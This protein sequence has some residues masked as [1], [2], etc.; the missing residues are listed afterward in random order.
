MRVARGRR[1]R[2][3]P[4][5]RVLVAVAA[6]VGVVLG[7]ASA[8]IAAPPVP[9]P[10][11]DLPASVPTATAPASVPAAQRDAALG[12]GWQTSTD[13][14]WTT[15][16]D[17]DGLHLLVADAAA[18]YAWRTVATLSE[19][20][21]EADKWI[22][23]ACVTGSGRRAV[24]VYA[25]RTFTNKADLAARGGFT[26]IVDLSTGAV[27]KL[28]VMTTL[29]YYNPGCGTGEDAVLT[30]EGGEDLG[31]TRLVQVDA[32]SAKLSAKI[33]IPGQLTSAVPT[34][35]GIVAADNGALVRVDGTGTRRVLAPTVGIAF[36]L[37]VD[38]DGGV[39]FMEQ[40]GT[41]QALVR[42]STVPKIPA[43][44]AAIPMGTVSTLTSGPLAGQDVVSGRAGRVFVTGA[45]KPAAAKLPASVSLLAAPVGSQLSTQGKLLVTAV[46]TAMPDAKTA[47]TWDPTAAQPVKITATALA[48]GRAISF[49]TPTDAGSQLQEVSAAGQRLTPALTTTA[50][51][52]ALAAGDPHSPADLADRFCSVPRNDP[53]NQAMQPKPRQVEWAVDQAVRNVL[54]VSRPA[55]WKNLGM[56][57]YTPQGLFPP[58]TL[59][60]GGFVPPQI[61]LGVA[62]QESNLWEA[63]RF[64]IPGVTANPLIG[65]YFGNN[66]YNSDPNDDWTISWADADCGYG[67][68]QVTDGMRLA[69]HT[70]PGETAYP[71]QTQR[72]VALDF[73]VNVAAGL[74]ILELKWNQV[75]GAGMTINNGNSAKIE[76]WYHALWAY[77]SGFH[78]N[79]NNG[80]P[81]GVGWAN[82]P[83]NPHY[84]ANREAFLDVT[85]GDAAHPQ[86]WP[87]EE[88]VIGWAGHPIQSIESPNVL[89]V[90]YRAASWNGGVL[91]PDPTID[92]IT[93]GSGAYNR[94]TA[95]APPRQFCDSTNN[96]AYGTSQTPNA[97][98]VVGEPAGPCQHK[99]SAGQYDLQCW[100]HNVNNTWKSDCNQTCGIELL[101][102]D[103][104]FA[105]QDDGN[106]YPPNCGL[107]GLPAGAQIVDDVPDSTPI[108]RTGCTHNFTN[109][110][111]FSFTFKP[112]SASQY[113]GKMDTHQLGAGFGGHF[114]FTH[115]RTAGAEGGKL[116]VNAAWKLNTTRNGP[117]RILVA[118]PDIATQTNNA[119]YVVK[120]A[121]GDRVRVIK[122]PGSGNRWVNLGAF[123][124]NGTP[125]VD[126]TSVA[127]DGSGDQDIAFDAVAFVPITG[128]YK[129]DSVEVVSVFDENTNIDTAAPSSWISGPIKSRQALYDWATSNVNDI[130]AMP[131]CPPEFVGDCLLPKVKAWANSWRAQVLA[132]GTDLVNHPDGNSIAK[133]IGFSNSYLDRPATD[134]R[135]ARFDDPDNIKMREKS[136]I[137]YV[138]G[139]DGKII[140][141]SEFVNYEHLLGNTHL[142]QFLLDLFAAISQTYAISPPNLDYR[143]QDL[144]VHDHAWDSTN[145]DV[146]GDLPARA[147]AY[148]G[149]APVLTDNTSTPT[150]TNAT[151]VA[152]LG[153]AGGVDGYRPMLGEDG[154]S[155][156]FDNWISRMED[157]DMVPSKVLDLAEDVQDTFFNPGAIPG[158]NATVLTQAPPIWA[159]LN[160]RACTDG[161]IQKNSNRPLLR[162]SWPIDQYF[163]HNGRA[164]DLNGNF[165]NSNQPVIRGNFHNFS[166]LPDPN[167]DFPLWPNPFGDCGAATDQSGNP[168]GISPAPIPQ[169][170]GINPA[171]AHF[172]L[173]KDLPSDPPFSS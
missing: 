152:V 140:S 117:M 83:A 2:G 48:T 102:F 106:S 28:P 95:Q 50:P 161:T 72:A 30:Q 94:R 66:I 23:N 58:E 93:P 87:Y 40:H 13:R 167:Q 45:G 159:E 162:V 166:A 132:A 158:V 63:A 108:V 7:G 114:W 145:P 169:D 172:C 1:R 111:T 139:S 125:E 20:G 75:R 164:I 38:A 98:D 39:V 64:A 89:V 84:P 16:G 5:G 17:A 85:Y 6:T 54:T 71:F 26:A 42:R 107:G 151:C 138:V 119:R 33:E 150:T 9:G 121:N 171:H 10:D 47:S 46:D 59:N 56:P 36:K 55:N 144:N 143:I 69:G 103:P 137:S 34:P 27:T 78:V 22:G 70:K 74:K 15:N 41:D 77:N 29:A 68:T 124:F 126:L 131:D 81:W 21:F 130:L 118:L 154:P 18:G 14:A 101:R 73:A 31:Q 24:V 65:N 11:V 141:G 8:A 116:E 146:N 53:A 60:G 155:D 52:G 163:Y 99:N 32:A 173:D 100:Y 4:I 90:G 109:A 134:Q 170:A 122:Q 19:P 67:V 57:A 62:A 51:K 49:S 127:A 113:P 61:M 156:A 3:S 35:A 37:N 123:M 120:T 80:T 128:T 76:N 91:S 44:V 165:S 104:G 149:K 160:Y 147:Y 136:T 82:N 157:S 142:P 129:E 86:D 97:P 110:G 88:K 133:W 105:Y 112:D 115:T 12:A 148:A 153:V 43:G 168:W 79:P 25:P 135:P 96:C 92:R